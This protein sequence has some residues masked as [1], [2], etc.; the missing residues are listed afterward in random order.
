MSCCFGT[1]RKKLVTIH[2]LIGYCPTPNLMYSTMTFNFASTQSSQW[3]K[4]SGGARSTIFVQHFARSTREVHTFASL[5]IIFSGGCIVLKKVK[6]LPSCVKVCWSLI[7]MCYISSGI[8]PNLAGIGQHNVRGRGN[9]FE[10]WPHAPPHVTWKH[11][12]PR[13]SMDI[14]LKMRLLVSFKIGLLSN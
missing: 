14:A 12:L 10:A 4:R 3:S 2:A 1:C 9:G 6:W 5:H 7:N 8:L 13:S 11:R